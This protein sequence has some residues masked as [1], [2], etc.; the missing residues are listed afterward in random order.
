MHSLKVRFIAVFAA[1]ACLLWLLGLG[2]AVKDYLIGADSVPGLPVAGDEPQPV[3]KAYKIVALGDSLTRGTGDSEGKGYAGYV[4]D[5]LKQDGMDVSLVNL[6]IKGL[7]SAQMTEQLKQKEVHRQIGQADIVLMTIGGNDL[8]DGG[9]TLSNLTPENLASLGDGFLANL[10]SVLTAV[11]AANGRA[12]VYVLGLYDPFR[13]LESGDRTSSAVRSWNYKMTEVLSG[14][15][16]TVF[17]PTYDLFQQNTAD[18][19]FTDHF[20]PN[21]KGYRLMAGRLAALITGGGGRP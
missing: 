6:G 17:V 4:G 19:L 7:T 14:Y 13:D 11:R 15:S 1:V 2:W 9:Q 3:L 12:V 20:H 8:F 18:Y 10:K 16:N 21:E 5:L